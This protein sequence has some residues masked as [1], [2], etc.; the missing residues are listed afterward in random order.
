MT[1][2]RHLD[3]HKFLHQ[4][5]DEIVADYIQH[6]KR[7]PCNSTVMEL[8]NWSYSQMQPETIIHTDEIPKGGE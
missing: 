6:T 4:K 8:M 7:L 1:K 2:Q 3:L 5:L